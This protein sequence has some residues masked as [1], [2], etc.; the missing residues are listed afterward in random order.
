[1]KIAF[2]PSFTLLSAAALPGVLSAQTAIPAL[3]PE[4]IAARRQSVANLEAHI[5]QRGQRV[6]AIIADIRALDDR[7]ETG[8]DQIVKTISGVKDSESSKVGISRIKADVMTGLK[9][10]I[11]YYNTPRDSIREQL[12][13]GKSALPKETLEK[14]LAILDGRVD[15]RVKQI[16]E[17]AKSFPDPEELA[18]YETTAYAGW[19]GGWYANEEISEAWKQNRRDSRHTEQAREGFTKAMNDAIEHLRQRNAYLAG[20]LKSPNV[21]EAE[22][23]YYRTE[24][25]R[26]EAIVE[27]RADELQQFAS[28]GATAAVPVMPDQAHDLD[29]LVQSSRND[30]REDFFAIFRKYAELNRARS[31]LKQLQDNLAARKEW[32]ANYDAQHPG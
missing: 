9:R 26:N 14:D 31:E 20:K 28:G 16:A 11:D 15:K 30:L 25:S 23:D 27:Q 12:R 29:Q 24:I 3:S 7:V 22:K 10:T 4:E 13:T 18:K 2:I 6:G 21:P 8:V 1:M 32:L 17:I 5:A 19:D